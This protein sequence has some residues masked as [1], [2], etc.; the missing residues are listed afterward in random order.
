M[1]IEFKAAKRVEQGTGASRRLR[2][3]G[4]L[5]GIIYG[6]DQDATPVTLDHNE[7]YHL[8]RK[9]AFHAS[10][11]VADFDG[12]KETVVLRDTQWHPY[13]QQVLH[14]DF[15]RVS[16]TEKMH[17]KV[18]LH[19]VNAEESPAVKLEGGM[20]SHVITEVD[21]ACLPMDLPEFIEVD[22]KSLTSDQSV[23]VSD[24]KLPAGVEIVHHGDGDPVVATVL[25]TGGSAETE[26]TTEA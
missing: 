24:L 16:A 8:L 13:K 5:P 14:V 25:K 11:L 22:L 6:A 2:R 15:Q 23:H 17:L 4:K 26:E 9:E 12:A 21:V 3:A 19:F 20:I 1:Q 18:P 7:L 10:V